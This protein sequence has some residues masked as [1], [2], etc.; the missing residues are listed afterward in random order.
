[1]DRYF[2]YAWVGLVG[3]FVAL[4]ILGIWVRESGQVEQ[5][6]GGVSYLDSQHV[7]TVDTVDDESMVVIPAGKFR[8]G[9]DDGAYDEQPETFVFLDTF[10]IDTYE[11][12]N[13]RYKMF[14]ERTG[15]REPTSRY[16]EMNAFRRLELPAV[17]VSWDDAAAFCEWDGKRLPTEAEWEKAARGSQGSVWPWGDDARP[18]GA[19]TK[20]EQ[21]GVKYTA[22]I[23]SFH[24][25]RSPYGVFDM[26]GNVREWVDDW[27]DQHGYRL[28]AGEQDIDPDAKTARALRGGSWTDSLVNARTTA[29]F[30]M[31]PRYRDTAIGFR[32]VKSGLPK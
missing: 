24:E 17:Y 20:G 11:V 5:E 7:T 13:R 29:R 10:S 26:A 2:R 4:P 21:D 25:D 9:N 23:G 12:T 31:L 27:Y 1:M 8:Q 19:N 6:R 32:C 22:P 18:M 16:G 3:V 30:K 14:V 15:H 28:R